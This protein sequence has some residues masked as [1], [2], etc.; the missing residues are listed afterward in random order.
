[1][2]ALEAL[3]YLDDIAHGRKMDYDPHELKLLVEKE[4]KA[5]EIISRRKVNVLELCV[6]SDYETFIS[7]FNEFNYHGEYDEYVITREEYDLL[8]EALQ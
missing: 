5:L 8:R 6:C 1:M 4:L 7:F 3:S 2:K